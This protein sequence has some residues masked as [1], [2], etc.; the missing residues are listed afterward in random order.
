MKKREKVRYYQS[1]EQDF[2]ESANQEFTLPED[3]KW[4]REDK[5]SK[6]LSAVIYGC[7]VI[8]STF[9]CRAVL[10]LKVKGR[11]NVKGIKGGYFI[12]ANHT[13][14]LGDVFTPALCVLPKRIYTVVSPA[15]YGIPVLGKILPY[16]GALPLSKSLKG[17]KEFNLAIEKRIKDGHPVVIYPEAHVWEYYE[18]IRPFTSTCMKYPIKFQAPAVA[19]TVTYK[20]TK[21]RKRP[22]M[23]VYLDGPFTPQGSTKAQQTEGLYNE[24]RTAMENRSKLSDA[25][26][27]KYEKI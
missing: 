4:I 19:M 8:F 1:F 21:F 17:M 5:F 11:K 20:K 27:I 13:Q 16:L 6:F 22:K 10:R 25:Q 7:A 18:G 26:Y 2:E 14:P 24:I 15:N 23:V 12:Y 3:Y 9:Y